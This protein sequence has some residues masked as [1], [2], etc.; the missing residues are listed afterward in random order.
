MRLH[1]T[2]G[3]F[4]T[5]MNF[6][7]NFIYQALWFKNQFKISSLGKTMKNFYFMI[8]FA[9]EFWNSQFS[10]TFQLYKVFDGYCKINLY[11]IWLC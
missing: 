10:F 9:H 6:L 2:S 7:G 11:E 5:D 3:V 4:R 8:E 1:V